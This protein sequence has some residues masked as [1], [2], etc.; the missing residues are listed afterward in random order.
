MKYVL[1]FAATA[2]SL[3]TDK[4]LSAFVPKIMIQIDVFA[5]KKKCCTTVD[6]TIALRVQINNVTVIQ[7]KKSII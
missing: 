4:G 6:A 3:R 1:V 2:L 5:E 7:F